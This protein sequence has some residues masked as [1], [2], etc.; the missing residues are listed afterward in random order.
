MAE[1]GTTSG[2]ELLVALHRD[3]PEPLHRQLADQLRDAIRTGRLSAN[4]PMPSTRVLATDLGLSRRLVVDVYD[5]LI[6]EGFLLSRRGSGTRVAR[7]GAAAEP[8][9]VDPDPAARYDIDFGPGTPDLSSFPRGAWIRALRH[10]L[11]VTPS[12]SLGYDVRGLAVTREALA[13]YLRRT[14][15][16]VTDPDRIVLCSGVTQG[17]G[18]TARAL[19]QAGQTPIAIEDPGFWLHRNILQHTGTKPV[20]VKVDEDGIDVGA[21]TNTRAKAVL[22]TPAH[23]AA[24]GVVLTPDRRATLV[25]WTQG[26]NL[27]VEDDYDAEYRY[28]RAPVGALQGIMP[29][30]V[31][32]LGSASKTLAPGL[33]IGWMVLPP[34]LVDVITG[35]KGLADMGSSVMDQLAFAQLLSSGDYDRHLR[36]MRRRYLRRR[37]ALLSSLHRYL[38]GVTVL[39]TAAGVQL[40]AHFPPGCDIDALVADA[41][42]NRVR[43]ESLAASYAEPAAAPPGLTLGYANLT[44]A[45]IV[46]GIRILARALDVV[47]PTSRP[48]RPRT[49]A[50]PRGSLPRATP[51]TLR[52]PR[53]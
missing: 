4:A 27:V 52:Q 8:Q 3:H 43:V 22:T 44:E 20:L 13:S 36:Q 16:V 48:R 28:D 18:L 14:R 31:V 24:T 32:Y 50:Q 45:Q 10:A 35:L 26:G 9:P 41:A 34:N 6:A 40:T 51:E 37:N 42:Q 49:A 29:N 46:A 15:A 11:A 39:G 7:I 21:L 25:E 12:G 23:Q 33:R 47:R 17:L 19:R 5:Q 38:P 1:S 2:P 53:K 30:R